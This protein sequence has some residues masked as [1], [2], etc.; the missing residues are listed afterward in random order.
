MKT[1]VNLHEEMHGVSGMFG[2]I[3]CTHTHWKN[4]PVGWKG[5]FKNGKNKLPSIVLEA[6]ADH[7]LFFWHVAYGYAG[8]LRDITIFHQSTMFDRMIDGSWKRK[9]E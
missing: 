8:T 9:P 5:S 7:N 1:I 3:D 6:V 4:C 2:S